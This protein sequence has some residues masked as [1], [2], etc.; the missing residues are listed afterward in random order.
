MDGPGWAPAH[1]VESHYYFA[2]A[3]SISRLAH[4]VNGDLKF[5][6]ELIAF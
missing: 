6:L 5:K 3:K 2:I 1:L 4:K